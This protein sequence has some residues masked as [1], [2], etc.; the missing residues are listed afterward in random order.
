MVFINCLLYSVGDVVAFIFVRRRRFCY[1]IDADCVFDSVL[2][3]LAV[4]AA[5]ADDT[6]RV[7]PS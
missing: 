5:E 6:I 3:N 4:L 7:Q 1:K 2:P